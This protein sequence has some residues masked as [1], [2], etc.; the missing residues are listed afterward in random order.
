M[1]ELKNGSSDRILVLRQ[2]FYLILF[3][4]SKNLQIFQILFETFPQVLSVTLHIA[5]GTPH[6]AVHFG[7]L[8]TF[9]AHD[10]K[11]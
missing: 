6:S 4:G 9:S 8:F 7:E 2:A 3:R 10:V 5:L 11:T 1:T